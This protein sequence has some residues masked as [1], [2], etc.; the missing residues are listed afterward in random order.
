MTRNHK[1]KP[2]PRTSPA[3]DSRRPITHHD[4]E[5]SVGHGVGSRSRK[6]ILQKDNGST[7]SGQVGAGGAPGAAGPAIF[8]VNDDDGT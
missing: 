5:A 8:E 3:M 7:F 6:T 4:N 1:S 2:A